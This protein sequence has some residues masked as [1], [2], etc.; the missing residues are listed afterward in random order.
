MDSPAT[1]P[2]RRLLRHGAFAGLAVVVGQAVLPVSELLPAFAQEDPAGEEEEPT[3]EELFAFLESLELAIVAAYEQAVASVDFAGIRDAAP[4]IIAHHR[5][6]AGRITRLAGGAATGAPNP[7]V[8]A[9]VT[10]QISKADTQESVVAL[11]ADLENTSASTYLSLLSEFESD[12]AVELAASIL[13]V[14]A[15][16]AV[17]MAA[18]AG[19]GGKDVFPESGENNSF[20]TIGK[21]LAPSE[22]PVAGAETDEEEATDE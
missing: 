17:A 3:Q 5:D 2:R 9:A 20:E 12:A 1:L 8:L 4:A 10:D 6:H 14:E 16:H 22:F 7:R 18:A 21:A 19:D 15:Q 13:P 11:L